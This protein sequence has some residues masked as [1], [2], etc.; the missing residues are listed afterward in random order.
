[1]PRLKTESNNFYRSIGETIRIRRKEL[2]LSLE[3]LG[4]QTGGLTRASVSGIE[5]GRQRLSAYQLHLFA[6]ALK[7]KTDDLIEKAL[8]QET[9]FIQFVEKGQK[10]ETAINNL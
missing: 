1:M 10:K 9:N 4:V 5:K 8:S 7:T 2:G 3:A 6:R